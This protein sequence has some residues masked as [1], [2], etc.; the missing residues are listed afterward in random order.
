MRRKHVLLSMGLAPLAL[1]AMPL[2]AAGSAEPLEIG[3]SM[4][5]LL[6]GQEREWLIVR[7]EGDST[8]TFTELGDHIKIELVGFVEGDVGQA[9]ESLS[10]S[11]IVVEG[12]V[13]GFDVLHP[14]ST[15]AMPPVFTSEGAA[16]ELTLVTFEISGN[17]AR[18]VGSVEGTLALQ[19]ELGKD[20]VMDEGIAIAVEFDTEALRI[21]Y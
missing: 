14:I 17:Q 19:A 13:T 4:T 3:G 16:V 7:E 21:E 12:A 6:D 8:A 20:A 5:G 9:R 15:T 10:L 2:P 18:V 1:L 11:I